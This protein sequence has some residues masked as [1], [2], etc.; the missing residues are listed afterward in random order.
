MELRYLIAILILSG[1]AVLWTAVQRYWHAMIARSGDDPD[2][3]AVRAAPGS[4]CF[5]TRPTCDRPEQSCDHSHR[6]NQP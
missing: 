2:A 6:E 1:G 4:C 5:C 3:L